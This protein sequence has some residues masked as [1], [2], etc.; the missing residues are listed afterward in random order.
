MTS[1]R[2]LTGVV[3]LFVLAALAACG[4]G[5]GGGGGAASPPPNNVP[6]FA[7]TAN[8]ND[9]TVSIYTVNAA[10]G[11]LRHNGYIAA[12]TN[13]GSVAVDPSGKFAY[14]ANNGSNNVSTYNINASTGALTS[15]GPAVAAGTDPV[16]ITVDPTGKFVYV[17]NSFNGAG[18]NSVSAYAIIAT[19]GA[20]TRIDADGALAGIQNF[21]AGSGPRAVTVDPA[22][23]FAYVANG[24]DGV[25]GNSISV[26][27][28]DAATGALTPAAGSPFA[29]GAGAAPRSITFDPT[30]R[31]I[32]IARNGDD[33]VM[34]QHINAATGAFSPGSAIG[35]AGD[36]PISVAI[37]PSGKFVYVAN[38]VSSDVSAYT[39]DAANVGTVGAFTQIDCGGGAGCNGANFTAGTNPAAVSVDASGKFVYVANVNSDN[40]STFAIDATTGALTPLPT[41]AGRNGNIAMAMTRGTAAVVYTPKFAYVANNGSASVSAY[42]INATTGALTAVAGSPFAAGTNPRSV[43]VDPSGKF[44]YVANG[45]SSNVSVYTINAT[46]GALSSVGAAVA[47]GN[48]PVSVSVDPSGKF[49][50]VANFNST[51]VSAY[52]IDSVS[53]ALASLGLAFVTGADPFYVTT[54]GTIQ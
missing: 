39:I 42:T 29:M 15:V 38:N 37:D 5:G 1:K 26:Y 31:V 12:G 34:A 2:T 18:G 54:T 9:N 30:G 20:L 43:S 25:G 4:G 16:S 47:A 32:L 52:R 49:A 51:S 22:G 17:A 46:T 44:A 36:G 23:K 48:G 7:Y 50:Y 3:A 14:V 8:F 45:G 33:F 13:P 6:R 24:F 19:T 10:T 35:G 28:I 21:P 11:Q 41:V 27:A 40:V 53:G